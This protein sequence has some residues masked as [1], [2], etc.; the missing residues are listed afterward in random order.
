MPTI[1][2]PL[3]YHRYA[4]YANYLM[5]TYEIT[6]LVHIPHMNSMQSQMSPQALAYIIS[7]YWHMP[8][9]KYA[10]HTAYVCATAL[11]L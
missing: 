6:E 3:K 10:C 7:H 2:M 4:T 1:N 8:P 9:S 5:C 11:L